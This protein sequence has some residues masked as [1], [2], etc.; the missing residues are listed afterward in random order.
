MG[1]S[2]IS[3]QVVSR[4]A[5][6]SSKDGSITRH[7]DLTQLRTRA[8]AAQVC[9]G[10]IIHHPN[11][12]M[13]FEVTFIGEMDNYKKEVVWCGRI[14]GK[15]DYGFKNEQVIAWGPSGIAKTFPDY[16]EGKMLYED[17]HPYYEIYDWC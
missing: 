5:V 9:K 16:K 8:D 2:N 17:E 3:L 7:W 6:V 11:G 10:D 13:T 12:T 14:F 4:Q 1:L 15:N